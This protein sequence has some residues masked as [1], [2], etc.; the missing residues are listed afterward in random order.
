L[1]FFAVST[2]PNRADLMMMLVRAAYAA[3]KRAQATAQ[4]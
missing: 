4:S 1:D 3:R 2:L